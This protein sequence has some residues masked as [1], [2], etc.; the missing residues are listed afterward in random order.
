MASLHDPIY[1]VVELTTLMLNI[2]DTFEFQRL[3]Y[4]KQLGVCFLVFPSATHS[5]FEHSIGTAHLAKQ[6][7][8]EIKESQPELHISERLVELVQVAALIH[9]LGHGPYSHVYDEYVA[10]DTHEERCDRIFRLMVC[11]YSLSLSSDEV[12]LILSLVNPPENS[13]WY[14]QIVCNNVSS[15]D[16]DKLD[17]IQRDCYHLGMEYSGINTSRI[18]KCCRV[19]DNQLCFSYKLRY[20]IFSVFYTRYRLHKQVYNHHAVVAFELTISEYLKPFS[21]IDFLDLTDANFENRGTPEG[22]GLQDFISRRS[23]MKLGLE[24]A[25]DENHIPE[26]LDEKIKIKITKLS[27]CKSFMESPVTRIKFFHPEESDTWVTIDMKEVSR[28]FSDETSETLIRVYVDDES[29]MSKRRRKE[30]CENRLS[31]IS[32]VV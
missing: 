20:D 12:D 5:R 6:F 21:Q 10:T 9:D 7:M 16:V 27:M 1:G 4:I 32:D 18:M 13:S 15:L 11:K 8:K 29:N 23:Q 19:I 25:S 26:S 3:R 22:R 28:L 17:Y 30:Y 31:F 14:Q 2:V 24:I